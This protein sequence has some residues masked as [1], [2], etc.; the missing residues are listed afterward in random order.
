MS[1]PGWRR[2]WGHSYRI[3]LAWLARGFFRGWRGA[4]V[5]LCRLLVPLDPWRYY[6]M[7]RIAEASFSGRGLDVS[8]PKLLI[9]LLVHEGR[10]SWLGI[11]LMR[12]EVERW[13]HVDPRLDLDVADCTRL[14]YPDASF[15]HVICVSVIE[16]LAGDG[17]GVAMGEMW[18]VLRPGGELH[19]TTNVATR[20]GELW[21]DDAIYDEASTRVEDRVFFERHYSPDDLHARL[22]RLPWEVAVEEYAAE[23][24]RGIQDRFERRRPWSY[25]YGGLLRRRCRSNFRTSSSPDVLEEDRHGVVYLHLVKPVDARPGGA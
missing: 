20:G 6:E 3:G 7:G 14:P 19:L 4:R 21:R 8:S 24:D 22:L 23:I 1:A 13:R 18:R 11:D 16:H 5:G 15:D 10:G 12:R 9:S 25:L 2:L 17:D